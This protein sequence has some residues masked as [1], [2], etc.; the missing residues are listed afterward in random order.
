MFSFLSYNKNTI[1]KDALFKLMTEDYNLNSKWNNIAILTQEHKIIDENLKGLHQPDL[2]FAE[3]MISEV[4][5]KKDGSVRNL[6]KK[7][8]L[9]GNV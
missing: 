7:N 3:F 9:L 2:K 4:N 1:T 5:L 6:K 8:E